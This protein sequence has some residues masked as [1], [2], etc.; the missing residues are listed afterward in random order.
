[1]QKFLVFISVLSK[2]LII[3][4]TCGK[5]GANNPLAHCFTSSWETLKGKS[6]FDMAANDG[7]ILY[8]KFIVFTTYSSFIILQ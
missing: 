6:I 2:A 8:F 5:E 3:L 4:S 1:M 7:I